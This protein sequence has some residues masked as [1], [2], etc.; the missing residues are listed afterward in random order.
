MWGALDSRRWLTIIC[1]EHRLKQLDENP[2][3]RFAVTVQGVSFFEGCNSYV[4]L[5]VGFDISPEGLGIVFLYPFFNGVVELLPL[6]PPDLSP[7]FLLE[8]KV[9]FPIVGFLCICIEWLF[10]RSILWIFPSIKGGLL[11]L[12]RSF[13]GT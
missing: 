2:S 3:L 1:G 13:N 9:V 12:H 11:L 6:C 4:V 8:E 10:R 7:T 5:A